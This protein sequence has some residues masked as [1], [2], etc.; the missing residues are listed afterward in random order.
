[1]LEPDKNIQKFVLST[2]CYFVGDYKSENFRLD[3]IFPS[4]EESFKIFQNISSNPYSRNFVKLIYN[5]ESDV[6]KYDIKMGSL[7]RKFAK[8]LIIL[9]SIFFGKCF[10]EHGFVEENGHSFITQIQDIKPQ[11]YYY[12]PPFSQIPRKDLG[13]L[14]IIE[15][16][17]RISLEMIEI[18]GA[19]LGRT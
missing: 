13:E 5:S 1:M 10:Y 18:V 4:L 6:K 3:P 7:H 14:T 15:H 2:P 17:I 9:M 12:I 16:P 8:R 19:G 11:R